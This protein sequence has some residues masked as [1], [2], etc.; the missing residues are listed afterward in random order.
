MATAVVEQP[1]A[2][3]ETSNQGGQA[4][5]WLAGLPADLRENET[6]RQYRTVGDF[7]KFH[8]DTAK[9][10]QDAEGRLKDS[11][12]RLK[13]DATPEERNQYYHSLGRPDKPE[14]YQLEGGDQAKEDILN[15][16]KQ[17]FYELGLTADQAKG[18]KAKWDARVNAVVDA[19]NA[20][21]ARLNADAE[22]SLK[23]EW[24]D[25]YETNAELVKRLWKGSFAEAEAKEADKLFDALPAALR[26]PFFKLLFK[27]AAKTGEDVSA[28]GS[29]GAG[30]E[31]N[32]GAHMVYDKSN[33][34]PRRK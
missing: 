34:P 30:K 10:L 23:A 12:P 25:K 29:H 21:I 31:S 4:P 26:K 16:W 1:V 15:S 28:Q 18:L 2:G 11:V 13:A 27:M 9:K 17:D 7:A 3:S 8:L 19:H 22:S 24:G 5:G 20:E 33:M 14:G 6:F 32:A